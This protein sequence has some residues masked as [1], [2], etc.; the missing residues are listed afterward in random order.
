MTKNARDHGIPTILS[1]HK[2]L[3]YFLLKIPSNFL[4]SGN[5]SLN[6]EMVSGNQVSVIKL[7][8]KSTSA[9]PMPPTLHFYMISK[10]DFLLEK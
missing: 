2:G 3:L 7:S 1:N 10:K 4:W 6:I 9:P 8:P 5:I